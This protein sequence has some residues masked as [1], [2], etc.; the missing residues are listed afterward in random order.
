MYFPGESTYIMSP[1]TLF[2]ENKTTA[3]FVTSF[4][5]TY[6]VHAQFESGVT[7]GFDTPVYVLVNGVVVLEDVISG[8]QDNPANNIA[9]FSAK[10]ALPLHGVV[11]FVLDAIPGEGATEPGWPNGGFHIVTFDAAIESSV[12]NAGDFPDPFDPNDYPLDPNLAGDPNNPVLI[13][14][15]P[16]QEPDPAPEL[17]PLGEPNTVYLTGLTFSDTSASG[18]A[19]G[20]IWNT[21]Y[22]DAAWDLAVHTGTVD[23]YDPN[24]PNIWLNSDTNM[25]LDVPLTVGNSYD[26][27]IHKPHYEAG[28]PL[29][30][31]GLNLYFDG[32]QASSNAG[33]SVYAANDTTG[34]G[35]GNPPWN[36][37]DGP[38]VTG[39]PFGGSYSGGGLTYKNYDNMIQV[40]ITNFVYY[41]TDVYNI[42]SISAPTVAYPLSGP[43]GT[44]ENIMQIS[45]V[46][47]PFLLTCEEQNEY[48]ENDFNVDCYI[49]LGD[50][51]EIA[52]DWLECNDP[53]DPVGCTGT[54]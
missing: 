9:T 49:N 27:T 32:L 10:I 35:D 34:P 51:A 13:P 33:I 30:Y 16:L 47:E 40:T 14:M 17:P 8:F 12:Y 29:P 2:Q 15:S 18:D 4:E 41:E 38:V 45:L 11:D 31:V 26:F 5:A 54:P 21:L 52:G 24:D 28:G 50:Y 7:Q 42:D 48:Y 39:W 25:M 19:G 36:G 46:L 37:K 53:E 6:E 23:V 44:K 1:G 43:D 20:L 3:R 22:N